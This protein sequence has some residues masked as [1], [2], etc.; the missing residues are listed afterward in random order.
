MA[1]P[2]STQSNTDG[3]LKKPDDLAEAGP[4]QSSMKNVFVKPKEKERNNCYWY[5]YIHCR[6]KV[7]AQLKVYMSYNVL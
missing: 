3:E 2:G 6:S 4:S 1:K 7:F 5:V